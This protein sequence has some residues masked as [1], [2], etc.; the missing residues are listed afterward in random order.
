MRFN[1]GGPRKDKSGR[2]QEFSS[3]D[4]EDWKM[5]PDMAN[6]DFD[7]TETGIPSHNFKAQRQETDSSGGNIIS[8]EEEDP[9]V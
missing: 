9:K 6:N 3:R 7:S 5:R 1:D 4:S 2:M 8:L